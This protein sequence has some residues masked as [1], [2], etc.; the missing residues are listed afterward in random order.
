MLKLGIM[1]PYFVP[2]IGYWQLMNAVDAYVIYD[3]VN[4]I[5][6]GWINRNR[7]LI[8]KEPKYINLELVAASQNKLINQIDIVDDPKNRQ[9]LLRSLELNYKK[10]PYY[11]ETMELLFKILNCHQS[12]LALFLFEQIVLIAEYLEMD[13]K[14]VL[15]SSLPKDNFL[16][17]QDKIIDICHCMSADEYYNSIGG[18]SLY[19]REKFAENN[20]SLKFLETENVV[21]KQLQDKFYSNLSIIDVMM[22]NS[23]TEIQRL[24]KKF[25]TV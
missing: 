17:G 7:I 25:R 18:R 15:S 24:L 4:F 1:Q 6:R 9:K 20:I 16:K 2:Y 3:D 23:K 22:F 13:T 10:A 14:F 12:N 5:N 19:S 8:G 21:Y 11:Y